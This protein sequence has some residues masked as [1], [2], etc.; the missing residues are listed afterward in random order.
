MSYKTKVDEHNRVM[1]PAEVMQDL[2]LNPG[3]ELTV[4]V[5]G[6]KIKLTPEPLVH[7]RKLR[8][9]HREVWDGVDIEEYI[10]QERDAWST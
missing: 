5:Q 4:S 9:L 3:D 2:H 7:L 1:L 10:R 6:N 8:G